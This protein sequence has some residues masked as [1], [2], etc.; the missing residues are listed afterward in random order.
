MQ[1]IVAAADAPHGISKAAF[2]VA[3]M[4]IGRL[5]IAGRSSLA[6]AH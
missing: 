1:P 5:R 3:G 2:A 6:R 4:Q